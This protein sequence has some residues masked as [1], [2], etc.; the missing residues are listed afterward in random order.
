[1]LGDGRGGFAAGYDLGEAS[2]RSYSGLLVDLD[3]DRD[4]DVVISN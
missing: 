3:G 2:D 1:M 4:L